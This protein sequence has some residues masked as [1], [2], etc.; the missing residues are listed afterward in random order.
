MSK[1][2]F[3]VISPPPAPPP[4]PKVEFVITIDT[5]EDLVALR[6]ILST[7]RAERL[8]VEIRK[9]GGD[10]SSGGASRLADHA[11]ALAR[12]LYEQ[13]CSGTQQIAEYTV[14]P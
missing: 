12:T 5:Q 13:A 8:Y 11:D 14:F 1:G 10:R 9:W 7:A 6:A 3:N 4:P 2:Q